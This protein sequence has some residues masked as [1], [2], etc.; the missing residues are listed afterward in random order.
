MK[1]LFLAAGYAT[2]LYP[3]T[4][5]F[6]K[7][8]LRVGKK[9]ILEWLLDD[10]ET[11]SEIDDY[12]VVTN[13][14][15]APVFRD[16]AASRPEKLTIVDDG[17]TTN[18]TRLGAVRDMLYTVETQRIADDLLVL[19]GDNLVDFSL[20]GF[21]RYAKMKNASCG[22]RY[23]EPDVAKL[24]QAGVA[25]IDEN[26]RIVAMTEKPLEP[27]THWCT[28][29]FYYYRREEL[30]LIKTAVDEGCAV[31]APGSFLAWLAGRVP[32][33]AYLMPGARYDVGSLESYEQA[34][35]LYRERDLS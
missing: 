15:F 27:R 2:R 12:Y 21:I 3:L 4:K 28:P 11:S 22:V 29:P 6:P 9:N 16:W 33:Y 20:T 24:R 1:C 17:T 7:P 23:Y 18:E 5:N 19:A 10:L 35:R 30:P 14:K 31:D 26:E 34:Q 25:E 32:V 13:A 8:L